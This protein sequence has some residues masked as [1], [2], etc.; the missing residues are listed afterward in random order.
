MSKGIT[1]EEIQNYINSGKGNGCELKT[2]KNVIK[3]FKALKELEEYFLN[4]P[5]QQSE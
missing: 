2:T 5:D 1:Y 4:L 3:Y